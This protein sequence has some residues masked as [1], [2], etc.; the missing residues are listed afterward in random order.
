[1]E[2]WKRRQAVIAWE[3]DLTNFEEE[4]QTRPEFEAKVR[5]TRINPVTRKPEPYLSPLNKSSRILATWVFILTLIMVVIIVM[6]AIIMFRI[7][8]ISVVYSF[9]KTTGNDFLISQSKL[10]VSMLAAGLNLIA[11]LIMNHFYQKLA[12]WLT[13]MEMPRTATEFEDNFTMKLF[14]FQI[15][16]FYSSL[17]YIAFFKGRFYRGPDDKEQ[18]EG[19]S[20]F[21][22]DQCDPAGCIYE[23]MVQY[24]IIMIGKQFV[25]NFIEIVYP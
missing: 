22:S 6:T 20:S 1:M 8:M 23:L 13:K 9:S 16:N 3:W 5:S 24:A 25:N 21:R 19:I 15:I 18:T 2:F 4:E 17:I 7:A 14:M 12:L 11:I 10:M